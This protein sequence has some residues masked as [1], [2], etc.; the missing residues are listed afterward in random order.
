MDVKT[1][2]KVGLYLGAT[3]A[4]VNS[5]ADR[6]PQDPAAVSYL[7]SSPKITPRPSPPRVLHSAPE[8]AAL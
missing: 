6:Y 8:T 4:Q 3:D 2:L 7:T 1:F 5:V